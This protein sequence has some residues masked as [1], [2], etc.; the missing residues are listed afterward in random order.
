MVKAVDASGGY[1][2]LIG[3]AST[4]EQREDFARKIEQDPRGYIAQP[5]IHLSRHPTFIDGRHVD[6]RPFV[7]YG[8]EISVLP[9]GLTRVALPEGSL[10]V[11][12]SQGGGTKDTWVLRGSEHAYS[13]RREPVLDKPVHRAGREP[14][15][16]ARYRAGPRAGC[17]RP[18]IRLLVAS[19]RSRLV[20]EKTV[21]TARTPV[22][23]ALRLGRGVCQDFA[24]LL[25]AACRG[26][27]L[28]ARYISGYVH[29]PGEIETHAWC[30]VWDGQGGWVDVD[31]THDRLPGEDYITIGRDYSGVPPNRGVWKGRGQ[32]SIA[33][34]VKVE[35]IERVPADCGEWSTTQSPWSSGAWLQSQRQGR[36]GKNGAPAAFRQQQGQQQQVRGS[37][38]GRQSR[39]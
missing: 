31:P 25:L 5:T 4:R 22:G 39:V 3:P 1:G 23:E 10:V 26:V 28:P 6:L 24:H 36:R 16:A 27:G 11:N 15:A 29:Q 17:R 32:E 9:G 21:T 20:Y 35:E 38:L 37:N 2:M 8:E 18:V 33:V 14:R 13:R 34:S 7:L 30:Q 12:S 19:V